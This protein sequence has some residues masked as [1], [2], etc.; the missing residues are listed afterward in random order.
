M[1]AAEPHLEHARSIGFKTLLF[2]LL[3]GGLLY[4]TKKRIWSRIEGHANA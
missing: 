2:L 1:W 3:F 4:F